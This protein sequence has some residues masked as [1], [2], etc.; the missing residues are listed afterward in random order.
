MSGEDHPRRNLERKARCRDLAAARDLVESLGA[1]REGVQMQ[2]DTFFRVPHGRLKL[3]VVAGQPSTLIGYQRREGGPE[4]MDS[5]YFV[6]SVPE[7]ETMRALLAAALGV[8]GKVR[9][10]REVY[11]HANVRI[12]LDEVEGL[13]AVVELEAV[14]GPE[15]DEGVS[16]Q[17]LEYLS[18]MLGLTDADDLR[19]SNIDL[20]GM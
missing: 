13:G 6:T 5:S 7:P 11:H 15:A 16:R 10:R 2:T 1:R 14:L 4:P 12:H 9:K 17:R 18:R 3:R 20:L 8:R 19:G